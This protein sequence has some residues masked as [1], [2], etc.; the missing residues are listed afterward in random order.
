M[1]RGGD[2]YATGIGKPFQP[3]GDVDTVAEQII[4]VDD[5]FAEIDAY[6]EDDL[7]VLREIPV[8]FR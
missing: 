5:D 7:A 4:A 1:Y 2:T 6:P 8:S 3:G